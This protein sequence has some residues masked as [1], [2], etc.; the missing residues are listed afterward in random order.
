MA[1]LSVLYVAMSVRV[2]SI[3]YGSVLLIYKDRREE[4]MVKL[5]ATLRRGFND[6]KALDNIERA[7]FVL[8]C[9]LWAEN[10]YSMLALL[11][12]YICGRFNYTENHALPN[13]SLSPQLGI[14]GMALWLGGREEVSLVSSVTQ[15]E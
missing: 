15:R 8:D 13:L 11:K 12:E 4:F 3:F 7:S 14:R 9:E 10:F 5:R 1:G 2:L 6:F